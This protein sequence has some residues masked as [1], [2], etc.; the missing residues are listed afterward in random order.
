M[1][2]SIHQDHLEENVAS[3]LGDFIEILSGFSQ[4]V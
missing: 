1:K 4:P 3:P 2:E